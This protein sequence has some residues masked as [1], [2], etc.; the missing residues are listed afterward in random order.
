M[1]LLNPRHLARPGRMLSPM[2]RSVSCAVLARG[3]REFVSIQREL[4][5][6]IDWIP[7]DVP[8]STFITKMEHINAYNRLAPAR[9]SFIEFYYQN[10]E[11]KRLNST[12]MSYQIP[13]MQ[14][15]LSFHI[16]PIYVLF[17][18]T[19]PDSGV[20]PCFSHRTES[21]PDRRRRNRKGLRPRHRLPLSVWQRL[22]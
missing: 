9:C 12:L 22:C 19:P 1:K 5:N 7:P 2:T 3:E 6:E 10:G 21:P 20:F 18:T 14:L 4:L 17:R 8:L 15:K 16:R 13:Y 11:Y